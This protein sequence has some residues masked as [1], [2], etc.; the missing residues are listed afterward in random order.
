MNQKSEF[1]VEGLRDYNRSG[2]VR[3]IISHCLEHKLY[4][5]VGLFGFALTYIAFSGARVMFGRGADDHPR[6]RGRA[7]G[8]RGQPGCPD[9]VGSRRSVFAAWGR[10]RW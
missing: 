4:F 5:F 2:P 7:S 6:G 8:D 3:W 1:S 9:L 10:W